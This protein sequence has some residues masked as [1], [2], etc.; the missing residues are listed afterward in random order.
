V[1]AHLVERDFVSRDLFLENFSGTALFAWN[2]CAPYVAQRRA[3][4]NT[5]YIRRD[6]E[7]LALQSW[8]Y[9]ANSGA[10][11]PI[12]FIENQSEL[13]V[14]HPTD[15]AKTAIVRKV[16]ESAREHREF[17]KSGEFDQIALASW[18]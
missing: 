5:S 17:G 4:E 3:L 7:R 11:V 12:S 10:S 1:V 2:L 13:R 16:R 9:Q 14:L 8:L 6:F 15:E 18:D